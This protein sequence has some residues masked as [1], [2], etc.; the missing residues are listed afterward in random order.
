MTKPVASDAVLQT[1]AQWFAVMRIQDATDAEKINWQNWFDADPEHRA[2]WQYVEKISARFAPVRSEQNAD[3]AVAVLRSSDTRKRQ[4]RQFMRGFA[5]ITGFSLFGAGL[6]RYTVLPEIIA[7]W[8]A[9]YHSDVGQVR[10]IVLQDGAHVWLNTATAI[11]A[12]YQSGLR[13]LQLVS[14]EI[15]VTTAHDTA[16]VARPFVV[17]TR[18]GRLRALGT[19]FT[20]RQHEKQ[21]YLAVYEGAVEIT[22]AQGQTLIVSA[23]QQTTFNEHVIDVPV[24]ADRARKAWVKGVLLAEDMTLGALVDELNRYWHGHISVSKDVAEVRVFG[25]YPIN[26][27]AHVLSMLEKVAPITVKQTLPW[28]LTIEAKSVSS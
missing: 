10:E 3:T 28:W 9:D 23:G 19:Q 17:D 13:R 27:P 4:R 26:D 11:N 15:M 1:A 7:A 24:A 14:G 6:W 2:A 25:G 5:V 21:T 8:S 22:T 12:D 18:Q 20:V 16:P